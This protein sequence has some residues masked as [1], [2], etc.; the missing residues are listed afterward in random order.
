[1]SVT[2]AE[3]NKMPLLHNSTAK[4]STLVKE[5]FKQVYQDKK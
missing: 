3:I 2:T 5:P 4:V 1:M